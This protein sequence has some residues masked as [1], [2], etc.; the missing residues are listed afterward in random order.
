MEEEVEENQSQ[1]VILA[2]IIVVAVAAAIYYMK[3]YKRYRINTA[4]ANTVVHLPFFSPFAVCVIFC[5][6]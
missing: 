6:L 5:V 3:G 1:Y 2:V 4:A